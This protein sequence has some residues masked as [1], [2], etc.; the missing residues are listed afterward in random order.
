MFTIGLLVGLATH[1]FYLGYRSAFRVNEGHVGVVTTF[2]AAL[3]DPGDPKRLKVF[4]PG[5]HAKF[6]WQEAQTVSLMEAII[7]LSGAEGARTAMAE[8][9]TTLRLDSVLRYLPVSDELYNFVFDM[10]A[11]KEHVTGLFTC[12]LRNEIANFQPEVADRK[13]TRLNSSHSDRSRMPSS[14]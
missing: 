5:L 6:P 12:L 13:S 11:P 1:I 8:D 2:G 3:R 7:D 14:A 9:G 4:R 10:T